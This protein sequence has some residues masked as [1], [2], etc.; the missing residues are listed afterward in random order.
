MSAINTSISY[1]S[2]FVSSGASLSDMRTKGS[3]QSQMEVMKG[4][5]LKPNNLKFQD[6]AVILLG[7][8]GNHLNLKA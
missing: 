5:E 6:Q 3:A 1:Q 7:D 4:V 8:L 2:Q